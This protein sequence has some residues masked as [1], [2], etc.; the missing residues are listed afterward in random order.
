ME[1]KPFQRRAVQ[2]LFTGFYSDK[3]EIVVKSCTGSG[4]TII[5]SSFINDFLIK[6]NDYVFIWLTP[7]KGELELQSKA[8]MNRY[9]SR[10]KTKLLTDVLLSGFQAGDICY[11]NWELVNKKDN[12]SLKDGDKSDLIDRIKVAKSSNVKFIVIIDESHSNDT[13]KSTIVLNYFD[14]EKI[15]KISATPNGYDDPYLI[16]IPESVVIQEELI[17]KRIVINQ[18]IDSSVIIDNQSEFL[19]EK[20][21]N[22]RNE[23]QI[24]FDELGININPLVLV[25]IPNNSDHMLD[26]IEKFFYK[27]D[28]TYENGIL[29]VWL[30]EKKINIENIEKNNQHASFLII[31]QAIATG[32]DCPRAHILVKL[33]GNT[34]EKF[35]IQTIG[36]IRRM[37]EA[38]HYYNDVLDSAYLYTVDMKF[39]QDVKINIGKTAL[40]AKKIY[41]KPEFEHVMLVKE[42]RSY[43]PLGSD[44]DIAFDS[45]HKYLSN[46][47]SSEMS[48]EYKNT[49]EI[50]GYIFEYHIIRSMHRGT[51]TTLDLKKM[52][53]LDKISIFE[54]LNTHSH[55][56]DFHNVLAEIG[57]KIGLPYDVLRVIIR[58]LFESKVKP[59]NK[60][61]IQLDTRLLYSFVINNRDIL[62]KDF[63]EAMSDVNQQHLNLMVNTKITDD[64]KIPKEC[65]FTYDTKSKVQKVYT[66]N[67]YQGY[68]SSAE[69][70]SIPEKEFEKYIQESKAV[71]WFYK[72]GDKGFEFMSIVYRD[73]SGKQKLFYPDYL[74]MMNE[75]I[76]I[77]ETKGGFTKSGDS[78]DIDKFSPIKFQTLLE[79]GQNNSVE[80]GFVRKDKKSAEFLI[81]IDKLEDDINSEHW[82][83]LDDIFK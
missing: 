49:M 55:G 74:V 8:K 5:M 29:G 41:I 35:D 45:I 82:K 2:E 77:I 28:I 23:I 24:Q 44:P 43:Q 26:N 14:S 52:N 27:Q 61:L 64:F 59:L 11:I 34:T 1:L 32:W 58:R 47:Y 76:W 48:K 60:K 65:I 40:E 53:S 56:R 17:K 20:A 73:N 54:P 62:T 13:I 7:G 39:V 63:L 19:L 75:S 57:S 21:I 22:K 67:V 80:I 25:Q 31:K 72:N 81:A 38:R 30:S 37:P 79:Y 10:N 33:R 51:V 46:K 15:I 50:N 4:K 66:K 42:M 69:P 36:R 3:N 18:D 6:E 12:N 78:E 16:D 83:L 68:L 71:E 70:R 9:Y